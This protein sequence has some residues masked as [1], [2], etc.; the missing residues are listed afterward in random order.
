[1][2]WTIL[3]IILGIW[4]IGVIFRI[5]GKLVHLLLIAA[6]IVLI[7]KLVIKRR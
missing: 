1:M 4:L 2:L 5:A 7:Y 6:A 3:L